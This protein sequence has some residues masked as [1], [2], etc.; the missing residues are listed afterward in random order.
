MLGRK[1]KIRV[2]DVKDHGFC[3][4]CGMTLHDPGVYY[5]KRL[6]T[7]GPFCPTCAKKVRHR[8]IKNNSA[9]V[10]GPEF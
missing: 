4:N 7:H 3:A 9:Y 8:F 6:S 5:K 1:K 2:S 10:H